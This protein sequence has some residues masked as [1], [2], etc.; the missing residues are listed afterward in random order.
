[1]ILVY[2]G[3]GLCLLLFGGFILAIVYCSIADYL[4][5]RRNRLFIELKRD[6]TVRRRPAA[7]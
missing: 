2:I 3:L 4:Y 1:M 7:K 6:H 5:Y